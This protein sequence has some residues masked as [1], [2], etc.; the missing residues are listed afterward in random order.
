MKIC[1]T[2]GKHKPFTRTIILLCTLLLGS[3]GIYPTSLFAQSVFLTDDTFNTENW[4]LIPLVIIDTDVRGDAT[5]EASQ[6]A[7]G[8]NPGAF[9]RIEQELAISENFATI[10]G[11]HRNTNTS[12]NPSTQGP[13]SSLDFSID[14]IKFSEGDA[15]SVGIALM[16]D[17]G[18]YLGAGSK[19]Q[20]FWRTHTL[21]SLKAK[22]F[23]SLEFF[24]PNFSS[25][26]GEITFGFIF[27]SSGLADEAG[28]TFVGGVDNWS[29][30]ITS[31]TDQD[32]TDPII[33]SASEPTLTP[34]APIKRKI[35]MATATQTQ[36][37]NDD[38]SNEST[39]T[40]TC[41]ATFRPVLENDTVDELSYGLNCFNIDGIIDAQI[42]LGT[43]QENGP[44]VATLFPTGSPTGE[45]NGFI[46][47]NEIVSYGLLSN[48]FP[49]SSNDTI[50]E[51]M[52]NDLLYL[53][54]TTTLHPEGHVRGQ[55]V[56][57]DDANIIEEFF[58]AVGSGGQQRPDAVK[59]DGRCLAIFRAKGATKLR[60]KLKCWNLGG[61][62]Q[63]HI[64]RGT[65]QET[66]DI[67]AFIF[68]LGEGVE[69]S[70]GV[71]RR[72]NGDKSTGILSD[73]DVIGMTIQELINLMS[74][75]SIYFN[76]HT[77]T[78]ETGE[79]RGQLT[80]LKNLAGGF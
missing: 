67:L 3:F 49:E 37:L 76:V 50:I 22:D 23:S 6:E 33:I 65:A 62:T 66:G 40:G 35:F 38:F 43:S 56:P 9:R 54:V 42:R 36:V 75:D 13:I 27:T 2:I 72:N 20:E 11:F 55:I 61:I 64:H 71:I 51:L 46:Q 19:T 57:I 16:Q 24:T 79:V 15:P 18:I 59:T 70:N 30:T 44:I 1:I 45:V 26:G 48:I 68:P 41:I 8:G 69:A 32:I 25:S 52:A 4:E 10:L 39:T 63:A 31:G 29:I 74:S 14:S 60:Y 21:S 5:I 7:S 12:Y 47:R 58:L 17:G 28:T 80:L 77:E 53:E 73:N 34:P 78:S